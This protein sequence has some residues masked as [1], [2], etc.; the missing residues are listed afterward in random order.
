[1]NLEA[2]AQLRCLSAG[3]PGSGRR[4]GFGQGSDAKPNSFARILQTN[5]E[6]VEKFMTKY[7]FGDRETVSGAGH[8]FWA[9][10]SKEWVSTSLDGSWRHGTMKDGEV[11]TLAKGSTFAALKQ[12]LESLKAGK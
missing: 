9:P 10:G 5:P 8:V 1:M 6:L 2:A 4:P 11:T 3:G 12:H 7:G